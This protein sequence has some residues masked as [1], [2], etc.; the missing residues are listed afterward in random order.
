M[1][2]AV[3]V[4][5]TESAEEARRC[6]EAIGGSV[7]IVVAARGEIAPCPLPANASWV[8]AEGGA[9]VPRLRAIGLGQTDAPVVAFVEDGNAPSPGWADAWADAFSDPRIGAAT[10]PSLPTAGASIASRAVFLFE[11]ASFLPGPPPGRLSGNNFAL[12]RPANPPAEIHEWTDFV[13]IGWVPDARVFYGRRCGARAAIAARFRDGRGFGAIAPG[14]RLGLGWLVLA[15]AIAVAQSYRLG[16]ALVRSGAGRWVVAGLPLT[17]LLI[18]AWSLGEALGRSRPAVDRPCGTAGRP[19]GRRRGRA[20]FGSGR[21]RA[22]PADASPATYPQ[23]R[24]PSG[25]A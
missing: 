15:P 5:A 19:A 16:A 10:G 24:S 25:R 9:S 20:D 23:A 4:V 11:Y 14:P 1:R 12:R 17:I 7:P 13:A 8:A 21:C 3:V 2:I 22:D 6:V 18:L